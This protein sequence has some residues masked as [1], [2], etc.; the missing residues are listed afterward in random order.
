MAS[1]TVPTFVLLAQRVG[2]P[3]ECVVL[4]A[5]GCKEMKHIVVALLA[6]AEQSQDDKGPTR[7]FEGPVKCLAAAATEMNVPERRNQ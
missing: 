4:H 3:S 5:H 6:G 7:S 2:V 1:E